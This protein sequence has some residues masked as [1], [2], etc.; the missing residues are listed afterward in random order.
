MKENETSKNDTNINNSIINLNEGIELID[1]NPD[2]LSLYLNM[3]GGHS[4]FVEYTKKYLI[5]SVGDKELKFYEFIYRN[6][7]NCEYMPEFHGVIEKNTKQHKH[8]IN[9]KKKCDIFFKEM[10]KYFNIKS[11]D[12]IVEKDDT[13]FHKRFNDFINSKG[14]F[15]IKLDN[16]FD[17]LK[18]ELIIIKNSCQKKFFWIFFWYIKWQKEFISDR[19]I[20]IQ[21]LEYE[22]NSPSILDIKI[23]N[24]KKISKETGQVKKFK[25]AFESLGCRIM[26]ISSNNLYFKS[27]YDTKDLNEN[28]FINELKLFFDKNNNIIEAVIKELQDIIIFLQNSFFKKIYFCSLLI[29]FDNSDKNK[30]PIV[31]L[32]DL[33]LTN[34]SKNYDELNSILIN[35]KDKNINNDGFIKC[36]NNLIKTLKNLRE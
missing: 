11:E 16:S 15:D 14:D 12:I 9:Y 7:I 13:S 1:I 25:G 20:I 30:I 19:Y 8:I 26:G 21:N 33:D 27:R 28:F 35:N 3:I 31:K 32:I 22:T 24:E 34:N 6:K 5:K 4:F 2:N 23:G 17:K 29:F 36:V 10:V 18:Q